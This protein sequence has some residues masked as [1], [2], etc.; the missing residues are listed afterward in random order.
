MKPITKFAA[1][2][3]TGIALTVGA[4]TGG[5][6]GGVFQEITVGI[7]PFQYYFNGT[8]AE[9]TG[10][11]YFN[12]VKNVPLGF[13]YE[14]TT[15]VP[16]RFVGE[17]LGQEVGYDGENN[18]IWVGNKPELNQS[19]STPAQETQKPISHNDK[20]PEAYLGITT[21]ELVKKLGQPARKDPGEYGFD[22]WIYN[23]D[24]TDY[25][26]VGVKDDQ[27][28]AFYTN[29]R[30]WSTNDIKLG[31]VRNKVIQQL[32]LTD[33]IQANYDGISYTFSIPAD[34]FNKRALKIDDQ[35]VTE[36]FFDLHDGQKLTAVQITDLETFL[37]SDLNYSASISYSGNKKLPE[38]PRLSQAQQ[39]AVMKAYEKQIFDLANSVRAQRGLPL[40]EWNEEAASTAR[41]HS[42][43]MLDNNFFSHTSPNTGSMGN[44][45]KKAGIN[46]RTAGEN[47]AYGQSDSINAHEGWM[48]SLGH[49]QNILNKD[50]K[51]LGV[52]VA[53]K[54]YTQNFV[55]Y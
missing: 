43:D 36:F 14:G 52:G 9:N 20:S 16:L 42:K 46:Y 51:T 54:Y 40:L 44:R 15:Y 34:T 37:H 31:T 32:K 2:L 30:Q 12:G 5:L 50:F 11:M 45:L 8:L 26:Q 3:L 47:I 29:S 21:G 24:Y 23:R 39:E 6:A 17:N 22:W 1:G 4:A 55:T 13:I 19:G 28:V 18:I 38:K 35:V 49:R 7:R 10:G 48:N 41:A 33:K 27:V 53:G 25:L